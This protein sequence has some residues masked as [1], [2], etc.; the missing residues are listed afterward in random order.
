MSRILSL[1]SL[2]S[3]LFGLAACGGPSLKGDVT[4]YVAAPL[5]GWQA[6]GGQTV[7]GGVRL[8][9]EQINRKGGLLGYRVKVVA[10]D[11][12]A[13]SDVAAEVAQDVAAGIQ[14]EHVVAVIGHYNSDQTATG[15]EVYKDLPIVVITPT[16]TDPSLSAQGYRNFFRVNATDAAQA[17]ADA[18][19]LVKDLGLKRIAIVYANNGY[20]RGLRQEMV[21]AL[22]THGVSP[23]AE[24]EIVEAA[25]THKAAVD[26]IVAL[27]PDAIF[28]AGYETEGYVILPELREAGITAPFLASDGCFLYEFVDGSGPAAEGAYVSGVTPD[29]RAVA[30]DAWWK[31]YQE[32]EKRNPG[33]YSVAGYAAMSVLAQGIEHAKTF[34]GPQV[35]QALHELNYAS[36]IGPVAYDDK[37]DLKQQS[38]YIFQVQDGKFVQI[39]PKP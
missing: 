33:T 18:E 6:E 17:P 36:L 9:A 29:S 21:R 32:V 13:D 27:R 14:S 38:I 28:L 25:N 10:L 37:G 16:A 26:Q 34:D 31:D 12:E 4:V 11:D 5:S 1:L 3:I 35:A 7:A 22:Q 2:V 39:K 30:D 19:F 20:G 8:A 15:L 24:I 23:A